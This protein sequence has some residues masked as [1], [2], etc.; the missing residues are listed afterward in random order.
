M[1][2][3]LE[4]HVWG[5]SVCWEQSDPGSCAVSLSPLPVAV[6]EGVPCPLPAEH[7]SQH[8]VLSCHSS[9]SRAL[10]VFQSPSVSTGECSIMK[11]PGSVSEQGLLWWGH[12]DL[13]VGAMPLERKQQADPE[14]LCT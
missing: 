3:I 5:A 11:P 13:S 9:F 1:Q 2:D 14:P 12:S 10:S 4:G 7:R 8:L 6:P